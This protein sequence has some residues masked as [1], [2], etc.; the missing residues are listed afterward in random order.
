M[1]FLLW[2]PEQ[3]K[4]TNKREETAW[5]STY[6]HREMVSEITKERT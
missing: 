3:I 6:I 4:I 5:K 1:V 2:Q